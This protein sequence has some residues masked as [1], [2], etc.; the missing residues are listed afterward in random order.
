MGPCE[1]CVQMMFNIEDVQ[2]EILNALSEYTSCF[3]G[4]LVLQTSKL[5]GL[6][7]KSRMMTTLNLQQGLKSNLGLLKSSLRQ[8][9]RKYLK[10]VGGVQSCGYTC[11][12]ER[13]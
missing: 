1:P 2:Q 7:S 4:N 5:L 10:S 12:G 11:R 8:K 3:I 6:T 9:A 13:L